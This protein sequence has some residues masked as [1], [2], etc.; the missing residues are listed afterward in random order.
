MTQDEYTKI[1]SVRLILL[2]YSSLKSSKRRYSKIFR[3]PFILSKLNIIHCSRIR[4]N[5]I[6]YPAATTFWVFE[7]HMAIDNKKLYEQARFSRTPPHS[8]LK[9]PYALLV[10]HMHNTH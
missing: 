9:R 3:N 6:L 7:I 4:Y 10:Q 5:I 1:F 8:R 2:D